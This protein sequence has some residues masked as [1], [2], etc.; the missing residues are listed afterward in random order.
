MCAQ[1][2]KVSGGGGGKCSLPLSEPGSQNLAAWQGFIPLVTHCLLSMSAVAWRAMAVSAL[3]CIF[4][5]KKVS[6]DQQRV[7]LGTSGTESFRNRGN[8]SE[9][10][11]Y[12][13][14]A[15]KGRKEAMVV[16]EQYTVVVL[17]LPVLLGE[18]AVGV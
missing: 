18:T 2:S 9:F 7:A 3:S 13:V 12:P 4:L 11:I 16:R 17:E 1:G 15:V 6:H 14:V 10:N 5:F 8:L